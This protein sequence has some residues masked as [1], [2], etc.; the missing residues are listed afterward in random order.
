LQ[1][2]IDV[3]EEDPFEHGRRAVL[4]LGHTAGHA[5]ERLSDFTLQHGQ[6][7]SIGMVVAA[8][9]AVALDR[10]APSLPARIEA[11][12]SHWGLP[13]RIPRM[14]AFEAVDAIWD[15]MAHDKK[16]R[17]RTLR[18]ILPRTIGD[19][20]IVDDVPPALVKSVLEALRSE[21]R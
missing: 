15:A 2:K 13:V 20:E 18:W 5:L 14:A 9:L 7:V 3:V 6:A 10:A 16:K 11:V 1:V 12:L 4:N 17:G 21:A 19:V 8:H